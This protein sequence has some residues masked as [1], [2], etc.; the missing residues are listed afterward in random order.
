MNIKQVAAQLY[1][2]RDYIK[3]PGDI[4][5]S[6]KKIRAIGYEAV[7]V[8]GMGP[9]PEEELNKVL[10]GEGLT[11][12]ATHESPAIVLDEPQKIIDRLHKLNCKYTAFPGPGSI[13]LDSQR[14]VLDMASRLDKS[15]KALHDAGL[16]LAYHNHNFEFKKV[17]G[18]IILETI[19]GN[20]NPQYLQGEPDTY[21]IQAGGGSPE[22]WMTK[23]AGRL[24]LLHM[25]D[26]GVD[27]KHNAVFR[28]IG[29]G[30]LEWPPIISLAEKAGC[31][32]FIIEQDSNWI[33]NDPFEALKMSF[34]FVKDH[35][36][37]NRS[38]SDLIP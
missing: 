28:E 4:V 23:L 1:S 33:N 34:E 14:A 36:V 35:L 8:S 3:T 19:Y 13:V 7:Q 17:G 6:M 25:K 18:S 31:R 30:N 26:Y 27:E 24:P 11:C 38:R 29:S 12:C 10:N 37:S 22:R 5:Q 2:I 20:T 21:W 15:G 32:W 9:I 16:V